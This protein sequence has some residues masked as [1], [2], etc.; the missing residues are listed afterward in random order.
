VPRA[1][2]AVNAQ[3]TNVDGADSVVGVTLSGFILQT[4]G[5]PGS[6]NWGNYGSA[7]DDAT[8]KTVIITPAPENL[9]FRLSHP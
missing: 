9:F 6:T 2:V 1:A 3:K 7:T 5:N 8:N 4:N